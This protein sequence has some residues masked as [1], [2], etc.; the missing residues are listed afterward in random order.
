MFAAARNI[1]VP[2][3]FSGHFFDSP[4]I[5]FSL[6]PDQNFQGYVLSG[7]TWAQG[8]VSNGTPWLSA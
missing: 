4:V 7:A 6:V 5:L 2:E 8:S 3:S 1:E